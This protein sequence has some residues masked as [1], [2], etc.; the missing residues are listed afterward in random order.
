[1]TFVTSYTSRCSV[2]VSCSNKLK[3]NKVTEG[4]NERIYERHEGATACSPS[5]I[6]RAIVTY[7][8]DI[9]RHFSH[10][11]VC[12]LLVFAVR[13]DAVLIVISQL[14]L[15]LTLLHRSSH[16]EYRDEL[17]RICGTVRD[18]S[19]MLTTSIDDIEYIDTIRQTRVIYR[20]PIISNIRYFL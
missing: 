12:T 5:K 13:R 9:N 14:L 8:V 3:Q 6:N 1:M 4:P 10:L 20:H 19:Y 18:I 11:F 7:L 15:D 17:V 16:R 2:S